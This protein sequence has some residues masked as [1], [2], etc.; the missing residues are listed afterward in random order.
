MGR[1]HLAFSG[2]IGQCASAPQWN[3][4]GR[5]GPYSELFFFLLLKEPLVL[6]E[7]VRFGPSIPVKAAK[8]CALIGLHTRFEENAWRSDSGT[9]V[10]SSSSSENNVG[11]EALHIIGLHGCGD[12]MSLFFQEWEVANGSIELP[13]SPGH[14]VPGHT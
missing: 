2:C 11:D 7:L 3:V 6:R 1:G 14:A 13:H 5:Y 8:A 4:P 9:S 10:S 12:T